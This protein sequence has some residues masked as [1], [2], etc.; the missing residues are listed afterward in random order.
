MPASVPRRLCSP[1]AFTSVCLCAQGYGEDTS[2]L[3]H[4]P[5]SPGPQSDPAFAKCHT[6][7]LDN[8][9][10]LLE[11]PTPFPVWSSESPVGNV[12]HRTAFPLLASFSYYPSKLAAEHPSPNLR[13][14][15]PLIQS[16]PG[17]PASPMP[18][19]AD[20][21]LGFLPGPWRTPCFISVR[22]SLKCRKILELKSKKQ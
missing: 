3:L 17:C 21:T 15:S 6:V 19:G 22:D 16:H 20:Q 8:S 10:F 1:A 14:G 4:A 2:P 11:A 12:S 18:P 13:W 9:F 5:F 7:A